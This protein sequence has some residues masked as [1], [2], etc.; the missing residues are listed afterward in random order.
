MAGREVREREQSDLGLERERRRLRGGRVSGLGGALA[1]LLGEGG[2]V[3]EEVGPVRGDAS[4]S[5]GTV[6][7][8]MTS[9]RPGR[10][11]PRT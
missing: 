8:E 6:S 5:H 7:P 10:G 1:I 2:L 11:G 9:L 3:D 4:D